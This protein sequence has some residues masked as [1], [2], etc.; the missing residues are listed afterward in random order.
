MLAVRLEKHRGVFAVMQ[1]AQQMPAPVRLPLC[2]TS[3]QVCNMQSL[4]YPEKHFEQIVPLR[5][6]QWAIKERMGALRIVNQHVEDVAIGPIGYRLP[7][8]LFDG[9]MLRVYAIQR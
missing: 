5:W 9:C 3:R 7:A 1:I 2:I 4:T 8:V 6:G